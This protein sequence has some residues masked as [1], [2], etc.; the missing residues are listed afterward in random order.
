M[1][2]NSVSLVLASTPMVRD[3]PFYGKAIKTVESPY[4][5]QR[6]GINEFGEWTAE[7]DYAHRMDIAR[8]EYAQRI[9]AQAEIKAVLA[10]VEGDIKALTEAY[11][12]CDKSLAQLLAELLAPK[13]EPAPISDRPA[14]DADHPADDDEPLRMDFLHG[15][16]CPNIGNHSM[17]KN[18]D[19][20]VCVVYAE[21]SEMCPTI[22]CK[23]R[24][25]MRSLSALIH[26]DGE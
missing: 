23:T 17:R 22:I 15:A 6:W 10:K 16:A 11:P 12:G 4:R 5:G 1:S 26:N 14:D 21:D 13:P 25:Q 9:K 7:G 2:N 24:G 20:T 3:W 8:T 18:D 19:G